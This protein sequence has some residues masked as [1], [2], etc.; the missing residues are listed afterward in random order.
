MWILTDYGGVLSS[1][2]SDDDIR[3]LAECA[4]MPRNEFVEAYWRHRA[5]YDR[6]DLTPQDYWATVLGVPPPP[7]LLGCLESLDVASWCHPNRD[8]VSRYQTL[9]SGYQ[10]AMLSN[11]P[12]TLARA[13]ETLPWMP[14]MRR[15][16]FSCDLRLTKPSAEIY[17]QVVSTLQA[18]PDEIIFIDD[19]T[20][21][22]DAAR[23]IGMRAILFSA[24]ED[25]AQLE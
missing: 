15:R 1:H 14:T 18:D 21:N 24:G 2:Q 5:D 7:E 12:T 19:R 11:A 25:L 3:R 23:A 9:D 22:I 6:A 16:F 8:T 4:G 20:E 10:F 17:R 13:V